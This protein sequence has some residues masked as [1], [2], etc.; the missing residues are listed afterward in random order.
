MRHCLWN[1]SLIMGLLSSIG[2]IH[3]ADLDLS[4]ESSFS[5]SPDFSRP[6]QP[7]GV[8]PQAP[9]SSALVWQ[10]QADA[11]KEV[12]VTTLNESQGNW[13]FKNKI[14]KDSR[15]L[16]DKISKKV[17]E[18]VPLQEKFLN[19]RGIVDV[20]LS[21]FYREYGVKAGEIDGRLNLVLEDLKRLE[22]TTSPLDDQEKIL[23]AE[24]KK[25]Q[26]EMASLKNDFEVLQKLEDGLSKSLVTMSAQVTKA[27]AY[28]DQAWDFYE[29]IEDTLSDEA[30][31][32]LL[33]RT[34]VLFDNITAIEHYLTG[35][36]RAFFTST[37]Q[38]ITE[39]ISSIKQHI[40]TLKD[41]G[42]ALGQKMRDLEQAEADLQRAQDLEVC[43]QKNK[44][45]E[46]K[47]RTLLSPIFDAVS[48][49]W[50]TIRNSFVYVFDSIV[51]LFT[52]KKATK[53]PETAL[54]VVPGSSTPLPASIPVIPSPAV[55]GPQAPVVAPGVIPAS[56]PMQP[57]P[58]EPVAAELPKVPVGH[59]AAPVQDVV[60]TEQ[61]ISER[62]PV[63]T[64]IES[65]LE[66]VLAP[67]PEIPTE[68]RQAPRDNA[69]APV[70]DFVSIEQPPVQVQKAPVAPS[71]Q[72]PLPGVPAVQPVVT[73]VQEVSSVMPIIPTVP[74]PQL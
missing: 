17:A 16:N 67:V 40:T 2:P 6:P 5:A 61:P 29:K 19:E 23:L 22:Q 32:E 49:L 46:L 73:P 15:K 39:K 24:A 4:H 56:L 31:E 72:A 66:P 12:G 68:L 7:A 53:K 44:Q 13:F 74:V 37:S 1:M 41:Q 63:A 50:S 28:S 38:K 25:K 58:A 69:A 43:N 36:F 65:A 71:T 27:N 21:E 48:W 47:K 33:N 34:H 18:I 14:A 51:G 9:S 35:E 10:D 57:K 45:K 54:S 20:A 3:G 60:A 30:A 55:D 11:L 64:S 70:Q 42:I 62:A 8:S 59:G 26:E 52:S